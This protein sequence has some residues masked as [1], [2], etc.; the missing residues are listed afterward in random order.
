MHRAGVVLL[1]RLHHRVGEGGLVHRIGVVLRL[2]AQGVVL[3]VGGRALQPVASVAA[4]AGGGEGDPG[5][6]G[7]Q[8]GEKSVRLQHTLNSP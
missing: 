8:K 6:E 7:K 5:N 4:A 2:Q 3:V 1:P